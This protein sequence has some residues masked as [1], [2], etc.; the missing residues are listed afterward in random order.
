MRMTTE[1]ELEQAK[2]QREM[3]RAQFLQS[4]RGTK[5]WRTAEEDLNWW[6]GRVVALESLTK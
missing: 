2:D 3:A 5:A 6:Q 4:K 1:Q